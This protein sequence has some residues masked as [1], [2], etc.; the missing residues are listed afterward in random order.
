M[1]NSSERG[2]YTPDPTANGT[3]PLAAERA[4]S[5]GRPLTV[6]LLLTDREAAALCGLGRST[7]RRLQSAGKIPPPLHLGR[8][9]RWRRAELLD[10]LDAG[11]P[12]RAEWE[13]LK[14]SKRR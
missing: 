13:A 11:A 4:A 12:D 14:K 9:C 6:A 5:D 7:W 8:S 3:V 10:W 1:T 2:P